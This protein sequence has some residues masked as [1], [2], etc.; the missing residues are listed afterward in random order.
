MCI[1]EEQCREYLRAL[2]A[3]Q[4][5]TCRQMVQSILD[6]GCSIT[7][8]YTRLFERSLY[9]VGD[10]WEHHRISV[11]VEHLA[12]SMTESLFFVGSSE[13]RL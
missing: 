4:S 11:A 12:T 1:N 10:L 6:Q 2:L 9:D 3:G 7:D 5:A 8:L 13:R